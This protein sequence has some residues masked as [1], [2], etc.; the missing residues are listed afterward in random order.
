MDQSAQEQDMG[1]RPDRA[2]VVSSDGEITVD[3]RL[4]APHLDLTPERMLAEVRRG[5]VYQV[6][7]KGVAA[8]EGCIRLTFRYRE[9]E[10]RI[11]ID[12]DGTVIASSASPSAWRVE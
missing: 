5:L 1:A 6:A 8:D 10:C 12:A 11:V 2:I 9:R 7:E 4:I 3:A